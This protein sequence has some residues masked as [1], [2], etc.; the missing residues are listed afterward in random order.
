MLPFG[1]GFTSDHRPLFMDISLP[2]FNSTTNIRE[3]NR[4]LHNNN[5][6]NVEKYLESSKNILKKIK[7]YEK[8]EEIKQD[9]EMKRP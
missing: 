4:I 5:S 1:S 2:K 9:L 6:T 7:I 8:I 3:N